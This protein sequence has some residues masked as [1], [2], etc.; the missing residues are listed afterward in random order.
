MHFDRGTIEREMIDLNVNNV[1]FLQC[2]K[3]MIQ[4]T[5]LGLS[6][7]AGINRMPIAKSFGQ[8][9]P[10]A[11]VFRNMQNGIEYL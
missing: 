6:V 4:K 10:F 1:V 5:F 9:A 2:G 3:N 7:S 11:A 8:P